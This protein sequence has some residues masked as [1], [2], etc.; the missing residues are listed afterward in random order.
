MCAICGI[1][2]FN[3]AETVDRRIIERMTL[4]QAHRGP[5][6]HGIF[7]DGNVGLGHRRLSIIDLEGGKQPIF[8]E[9]ES[10]VVVF[11]GEIYNYA[12]L[13]SQ[14]K[15]K[16]RRFKTNS[17]TETIVHAYEESGDAC[18]ASLRGMFAFALWDRRRRRLLLARDRL[19]IKPLYYYANNRFLVFASEIKALLE[20]PAVPREMDHQALDL[21]LALRY[22]PGPRTMFRNIFKLE[23]GRVMTADG[24]GI[25]VRKY[26][27]IEYDESHLPEREWLER[28]ATLLE[29]S[30]RLH[31]IADVPLGVFL[32]GGLDSSAML[33]LTSRIR[34]NGRVKTFSVGYDASGAS[35]RHA[36]RSNEFAYA[37][38]AAG[39]FGADHYE[40]RLTARAFAAAIP[41]VV[42]HLDEPL[43]D[44]SC[45]PLYFLSKLA[46]EHVT[47]V[48]SGEGADEVLGG[49][50]LYRRILR[51]EAARRNFGGI[52]RRLA[53][54]ARLPVGDRLRAYLRRAA[55]PLENHYRGVVKGVSPEVRLELTGRE[56]W[57]K[58]EELLTEIFGAHFRRVGNA[59]L[60]NRMLYADA[61]VWLPENLLLKADKMTMAAALELRVP[62]LDHKL[63]ELAAAMP[64]SMKIRGQ[65]GKWILRSTMN[66]VLPTPILVRRKQGFPSPTAAWLRRELRD[67]VHDTVLSPSAA[68][69]AYFRPAAVESVVHRHETE[70]DDDYQDVWSLVVFEH[71]RRRFIQ[72]SGH[73]LATLAS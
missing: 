7:T 69:R 6:D 9:D 57:A 18:V 67:F 43:A 26:W 52:L 48:L 39:R 2:N 11:N 36:E 51:L 61:K 34:N 14:L 25:R 70:R 46:R 17:D 10:I 13:T 4:A 38:A 5:D 29:E 71:W 45:I 62:F 49:Y 22:V 30:V 3:A 55:L 59:G 53:P 33:A 20:H 47:V 68:C 72:G 73:K 60:L 16:G 65:D 12:E 35:G 1:V 50:A 40:F 54:A 24:A 27:D 42:A 21:Y 63:V 32:S 37:R 19:G 23:P 56:R 66:G 8:N 15:A 44:P 31:L 41:H 58:T 28:F 64:D